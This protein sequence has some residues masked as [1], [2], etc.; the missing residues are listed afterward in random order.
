[1]HYDV[2]HDIIQTD[3]TMSSQTVSFRLETKKKQKLDSIAIMLDRDRSYILNE[4]IDAYL[5]VHQ[6]QIA[7]IREGIRQADAGDFAT[8]AQVVAAFR[9]RRK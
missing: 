1:V 2:L 5:D 4:A 6:W 7:H 3:A 8:E 9:R